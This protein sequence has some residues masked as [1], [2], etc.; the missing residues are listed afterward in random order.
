MSEK[1]SRILRQLALNSVLSSAGD[2]TAPTCVI[3]ASAATIT[4]AAFTATFTF[5]EDVTGFALG[6]ITVS[7][8]AGA[9]T[10]VTVS[11]SVYTAVITPTATGTVTVDVAAD[12][13]T[14][15]AGNNNTAATQFSILYVAAVAWFDFSDLTTLF[16]DAARSTP[17]TTNNDPIGGV[18][19]KSGSNNHASQ[20]TD[21]NRP[22]YKTNI[23]NSKGSGLWDGS[24]DNLATGN[25]ASPPATSTI[26]VVAKWTT[27]AGDRQLFDGLDASNRH[28]AWFIEGGSDT[29]NMWQGSVQ[30]AS[31]AITITNMAIYSFVYT[32]ST[33]SRGYQNGTQVINNGNAGSTSLGKLNIGTF[34]NGSANPLGGYIA[35][36]IVIGSVLADTPRQAVESYLNAKW[37][38][39]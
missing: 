20:G 34:F 1:R 16:Q 25:F 12:V 6:D 35:E 8:N 21:A 15:A 22:L 30:L 36:L 38:C 18:A 23:Q 3:T 2:T 32:G 31:G 27:G 26:F 10:F 17:V 11:P 33:T 5:S 7:A 13:C 37:A 9:G 29:V 39:F 28:A 19:D 4:A 14:D 24:N